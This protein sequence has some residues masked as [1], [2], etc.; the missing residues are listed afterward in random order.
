MLG[1]LCHTVHFY[2]YLHTLFPPLDRENGLLSTLLL[3]IVQSIMAESLS[4]WDKTTD[5]ESRD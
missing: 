3:Q 5:S 2:V 1:S 4:C